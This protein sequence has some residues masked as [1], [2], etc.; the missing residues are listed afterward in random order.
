MDFF[1]YYEGNLSLS[2]DEYIYTHL[3]MFERELAVMLA[4]PLRRTSVRKASAVWD[5]MA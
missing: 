3:I 1:Y 2:L 5:R 4:P